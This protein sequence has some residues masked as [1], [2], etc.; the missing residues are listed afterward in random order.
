M[1]IRQVAKDKK[2]GFIYLNTPLDHKPELFT[3]KDGVHPNK[4]GYR[5]IA[6]IVCSNLTK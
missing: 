3:E 5:T 2:T 6:E 4:E 1:Y